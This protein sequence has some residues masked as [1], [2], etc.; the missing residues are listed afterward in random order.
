MNNKKNSRKCVICG[1]E[2]IPYRKNVRT[3]SNPNCKKKLKNEQQRAWYRNNYTRAFESRR[4]FVKR[5]REECKVEKPHKRKPDTIVAI[6]YAE[7]Q[8]AETLNIV[9]RVKTEL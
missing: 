1:V 3:C 8:I 6:G 7:R 5:T 4:A 2:F 9:G